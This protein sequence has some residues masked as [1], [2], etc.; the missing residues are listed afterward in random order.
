MSNSKRRPLLYA[1]TTYCKLMVVFVVATLPLGCG[2]SSEATVHGSV[3]FDQKLLSS[4]MVTFNPASGVGATS[5]GQIQADGSYEIQ[6]GKSRG[7]VAGEYVVTVVATEPMTP[8]LAASLGMPR[9]ITP[10]RYAS[11]ATSDLRCTVVPGAN[12]LDCALVP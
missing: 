4:G 5:Y 10:E 8:A 2:R 3:T 11:P 6:T 9:Q 7:L 12:T 1:T